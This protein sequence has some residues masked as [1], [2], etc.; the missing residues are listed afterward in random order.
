[1]DNCETFLRGF[2]EANTLTCCNNTIDCSWYIQLFQKSKSIFNV[3]L[4]ILES[5]ILGK[6][7]V[8]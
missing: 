8:L 7:I 2:N 5:I 1:M 6:T 3:Y 4:S